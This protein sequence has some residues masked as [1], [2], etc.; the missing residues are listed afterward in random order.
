MPVRIAFGTL[1]GTWLHSCFLVFLVAMITP[2]LQVKQFLVA[3]N[4]D[5]LLSLLRHCHE[6]SLWLNLYYIDPLIPGEMALKTVLLLEA[7]ANKIDA[8]IFN[9]FTVRHLV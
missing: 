2:P 7:N 8:S 9:K 4:R 3:E 6:F 5:D 1:E